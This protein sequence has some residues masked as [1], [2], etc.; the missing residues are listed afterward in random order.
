MNIRQLIKAVLRSKLLRLFLIGET[1]CM[2]IA[3]VFAVLADDWLGIAAFTCAWGTII[4]GPLLAYSVGHRDGTKA[5][6]ES[7]R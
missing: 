1:L 4:I 6:A 7:R 2:G 3:V 5:F